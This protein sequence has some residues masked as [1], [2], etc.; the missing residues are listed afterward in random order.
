MTEDT[1]NILA[2]SCL[3][4]VCCGSG[5]VRQPVVCCNSKEDDSQ[6]ACFMHTEEEGPML[7]SQGWVF[8]CVELVLL[9]L[10]F[11]MHM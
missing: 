9:F 6:P 5:A 2:V 4:V 8:L 11:F 1:P 10:N 3:G 7:A